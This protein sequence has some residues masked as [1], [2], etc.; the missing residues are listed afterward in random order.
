M[1]R[2]GVFLI[3]VVIW[4]SEQLS[5][6]RQRASDYVLAGAAHMGLAGVTIIGIVVDRLPSL[7]MRVRP[8]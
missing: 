1:G 5:R 8:T 2:L 6:P 3:K 7:R 4:A